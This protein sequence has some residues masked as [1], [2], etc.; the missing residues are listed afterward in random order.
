MNFQ[1][2]HE[3]LRLELLR[4]IDRGILTGTSLARQAGFQQ[5]HISN[6]LNR[7]RSLSLDGLDRVL[8]AQN[9]TVDQ[10]MPLELSAASSPIPSAESIDAIPIV[11]PSTA[12]DEAIVRA[13]SVIETVQVATSRLHANRSRPSPRQAHWQRFLAIRADEQQA[14]AMDPILPASAIVV[15]DRHYNSIAPYRAQQRTIYAVRSGAG[16]VLRYVDFDAGTLILRPLAL[17]FPVQLL[18]LA[19]HQTPADYLIGRVC[20]VIAEL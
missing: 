11:S 7:K 5:A 6:Y 10:I 1:D 20:L 2:L 15:L 18:A 14:A 19:P 3:Q 8:A 9:L 17:A 4:R 13:E 12:T 16:L